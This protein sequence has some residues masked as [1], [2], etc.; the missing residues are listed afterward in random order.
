[1]DKKYSSNQISYSIGYRKGR[2]SIMNEI[3]EVKN[4]TS[5]T[6]CIEDVVMELM[7]SRCVAMH[8]NAMRCYKKG[9]CDGQC[10]QFVN[11][12]M[13]LEEVCWD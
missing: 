8:N 4:E 13:E 1:M 10:A 7:S 2:E 12:I 9:K 5:K 3:K 6:K 11:A